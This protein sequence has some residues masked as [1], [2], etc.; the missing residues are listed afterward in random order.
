MKRVL[1]L[2]AGFGEGHN[3]AARALHAAFREQPGVAPEIVDVFALGAPR[4]NHLTRR[5]YQRIIHHAPRVWSGFYSWLDRS[6]RAPLLFRGL[7]GCSRRLEELI[8]RHAPAALV[9]TFPIYGWM[10][11]RSRA[12]GRLA[13]P[14][15]TVVTDALTINS[16]WYRWPAERWF[17]PDHDSAH[18]LHAAGLPPGRVQVS[19]FPVALA[20]ADRPAAL[21]PPPLGPGVRPRL[22]YMVNTDR[23]RARATAAAL[24]RC[25]DW[26]LTITTGRDERLR[27][28]LTALARGAAAPAELLGWTDRIPEL[29]MTHHLV[30]SKAGG[31]TTQEAINALCPMVVS[32]IVPGQE[33]GNYELLRRHD[34]GALATT[35]EAIVA[36][37]R[38]AFAGD[39][40]PWRRW[41]AH[42]HAL[43]HPAAARTIAT[44]VLAATAGRATHAA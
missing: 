12:A 20:F 43:A 10:L 29:L 6:A 4:L 26:R 14:V 25:P 7:A 28:E 22:L 2:T 16:L 8:V 35:P 24:L 27:R 11:A 18:C 41:R 1:L 40:E 19:G 32:Q 33:A 15:F 3:S 44:H 36:T 17:V 34:A 42:L 13:C 9:S 30:I 23:A 21:Q 37:A 39:A 5:A 38:A 31:A